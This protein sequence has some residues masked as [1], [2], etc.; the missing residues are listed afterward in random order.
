MVSL[1]AVEAIAGT[2]WPSHRSAVTTAPDPRKGERL[3]LVTENPA[4]TRGAFIAHA[5]AAGAS[6]LMIPSEVI[7]VAS[8]PVL[9]TGKLDHGAVAKLVGDREDQS[10]PS[11]T[12]VA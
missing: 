9:A 3:I 5:K 6:D 7:V 10:S 12:T 11:L 1:A 2:L 4:A 8:V